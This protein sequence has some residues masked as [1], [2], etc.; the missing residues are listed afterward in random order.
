MLFFKS[1]SSPSFLIIIFL[2]STFIQML[3][4]IYMQKHIHKYLLNNSPLP[5]AFTWA[6][7]RGMQRG[8]FCLEQTALS[9]FAKPLDFGDTPAPSPSQSS[10]SLFSAQDTYRSALLSKPQ[11]AEMQVCYGPKAT[12]PCFCG[13]ITN[14][15]YPVPL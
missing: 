15:T 14:L 10:F 13:T 3:R 5:Q 11:A 4:T 1:Q 7:T 6:G 12:Q 9:W 2:F 8:S